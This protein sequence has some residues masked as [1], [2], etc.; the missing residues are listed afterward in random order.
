[1]KKII[2][3]FF[4]ILAL[5]L[6]ACGNNIRVDAAPMEQIDVTTGQ[7]LNTV[8]PGPDSGGMTYVFP[9]P[10]ADINKEQKIKECID[11]AVESDPGLYITE[12]TGTDETVDLGRIWWCDSTVDNGD[13]VIMSSMMLAQAI[14]GQY[15]NAVVIGATAL[16]EGGKLIIKAAIVLLASVALEQGI[17]GLM[18][19]HSDKSH[20]PNIDGTD[21]RRVITAFIA[22]W[23]A[24]STG[25]GN[26]PRSNCGE[27]RDAT[28]ALI[29]VAFAFFDATTGKMYTLWYWAKTGGTP[30]GGAYQKDLTGKGSFEEGPKDLKPGWSW[31]TGTC[32]GSGNFIPGLQPAQPGQ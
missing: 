11:G 1:M 2:F 31:T 24:F 30:W 7:V 9:T 19:Y 27:V 6:T 8:M 32:G 12:L 15:D 29:K 5:T 23:M 25:N 14:P 4:A 16:Y 28:G 22:A 13:A 18:V 10:F 26:D 20:S 3:A 21:A 17:E